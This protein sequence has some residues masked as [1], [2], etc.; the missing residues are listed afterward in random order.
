MRVNVW[1]PD[2]LSETVKTR[3]PRVNVSQ[4]LQE[5]LR[6]LLGCRHERAVCAACAEPVD[7]HAHG[8]A[9]LERFYLDLFDGL[10]ELVQHGGTAEGACRV[11]KDIGTRHQIPVAGKRPLPRPTRAERIAAK[12][13]PFP[14]TEAIA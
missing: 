13:K 1:L 11:A 5:G 3:M 2:D 9:A 8:A 6:S 14:G 10:A 4:V 7:V 12:V